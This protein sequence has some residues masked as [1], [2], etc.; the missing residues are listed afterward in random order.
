MGSLQSVT[1]PK[2]IT[3]F[4]GTA[5]AA[6]SGTATDLALGSSTTGTDTLSSPFVDYT[7]DLA[8]VGNDNGILYRIKNVFCTTVSC[9][10]AAPSLDTSWAGAVLL[11]SCVAPS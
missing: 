11:P 1:S 6:G 2:V 9:G 3:T 5:L 8:Y 7:R 10:N 4:S